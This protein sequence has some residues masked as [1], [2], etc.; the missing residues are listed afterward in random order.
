MS[1][2]PPIGE[3]LQRDGIAALQRRLDERRNASVEDGTMPREWSDEAQTV[4]WCRDLMERW[5]EGGL[6]RKMAE[7]L[8]HFGYT[9]YWDEGVTHFDS[10]APEANLA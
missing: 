4:G 7:L 5:P 1:E 6:R 2:L 9:E 3:A 8:F 10:R